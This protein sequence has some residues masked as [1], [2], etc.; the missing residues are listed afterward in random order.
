M[1]LHRHKERGRQTWIGP[2]PCL[3][4]LAGP[5]HTQLGD[6]GG[7]NVQATTHQEPG[8]LNLDQRSED[9]QDR[10]LGGLCLMGGGGQ[11]QSI[12]EGRELE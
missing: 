3:G 11:G 6:G 2:Q 8:I 1:G 9:T 4:Q 10:I 12:K 7:T 5:G